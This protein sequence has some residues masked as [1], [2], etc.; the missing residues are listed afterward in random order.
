MDVEGEGRGEGGGEGTG[1]A[2]KHAAQLLQL[3]FSVSAMT[4]R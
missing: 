4:I 1:T 2:F 3:H